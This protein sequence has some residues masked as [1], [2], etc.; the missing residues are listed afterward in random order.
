MNLQNRVEKLEQRAG[1]TEGEL[2]TH[3][4]EVRVCDNGGE[5][6]FLNE[7]LSEVDL[8][9]AKICDVCGRARK[10]IAVV[11]VKGRD[12]HDAAGVPLP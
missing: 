4:V 3:D 9:P 11:C 6:Y 10:Q 8:A 7:P 2:C 1:L 12:E 5:G